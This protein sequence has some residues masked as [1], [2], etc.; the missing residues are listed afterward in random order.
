MHHGILEPQSALIL[1]PNF[2]LA[3]GGIYGSTVSSLFPQRVPIHYQIA[4]RQKSLSV[5]LLTK[6]R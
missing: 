2:S 1:F 5:V 4:D 3:L 6:K